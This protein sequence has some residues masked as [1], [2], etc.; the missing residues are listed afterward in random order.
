MY[1]CIQ[2]KAVC[3]GVLDVVECIVFIHRRV[4]S[5]DISYTSR[6]FYSCI[7]LIDFSADLEWW[8]ASRGVVETELEEK[9][10]AQ[11]ER[12]RVRTTRIRADR[13]Q[14]EDYSDDDS[15]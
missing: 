7:I 9:P 5:Y 12:T 8:L 13:R 1:P 2:L 11:A 3:E 6:A 14:H 15:V 10:H 4:D